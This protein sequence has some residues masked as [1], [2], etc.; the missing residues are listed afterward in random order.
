MNA[1]IVADKCREFLRLHDSRS[2]A[3]LV[4]A[5]IAE[6]LFEIVAPAYSKPLEDQDE[7]EL[8]HTMEW[9]ASVI[10]T[11]LPQN[12]GFILLASTFGGGIAQYIS[13]VQR[14]DAEG[15]MRETLIRWNLGDHVERNHA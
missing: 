13:N 11:A 7:Q 10:K 4:N 8:R 9:T 2:E 3:E 12:T 14:A 5:A 6:M 1:Y 15:W